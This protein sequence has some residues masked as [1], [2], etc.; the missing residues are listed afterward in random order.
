MRRRNIVGLGISCLLAAACAGNQTGVQAPGMAWSLHD[1]E[2]EGAKLAFGEP[3]SDNLLLMM[4]CQPRT[5]EVLVTMAAPADAPPEAIELK[6]RG[7]VSRL[8]GQ[9]VP[10]MGEGAALIEA[11]TTASDPTLR[12]FARTGDLTLA[13]DGP[14]ARLPV[15]AAERATVRRFLSTC[16]AA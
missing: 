1:S 12:A 11:Q 7:E 9:V 10:A 8:D 13:G 3:H 2:G 5:G 16:A 15:R 4:T 6:S 14:D